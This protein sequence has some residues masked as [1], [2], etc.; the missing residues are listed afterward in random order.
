[1]SAEASGFSWKRGLIAGLIVGGIF[2]ASGAGPVMT[3]GALVVA[4]GLGAIW[5]KIT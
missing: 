4:F 2:F 5:R 1:M 3:S